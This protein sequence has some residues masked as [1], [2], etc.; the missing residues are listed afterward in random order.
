MCETKIDIN[1][2]HISLFY[3]KLAIIIFL[4]LLSKNVKH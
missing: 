2:F 4:Y 3:I 1:K